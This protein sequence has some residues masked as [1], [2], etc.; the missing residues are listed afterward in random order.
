MRCDLLDSNILSQILNLS[1]L[2]NSVLIS[3]ESPLRLAGYYFARSQSRA[4]FGS[5]SSSAE[6]Q[7]S[8]Y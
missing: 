7:I 4:F 8:D 2:S 6:G 3:I 5:L 1:L